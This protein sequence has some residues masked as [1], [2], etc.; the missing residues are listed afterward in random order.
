MPHEREFYDGLKKYDNIIFLCHRNADVD[1]LGSAYALSRLFGGVVGVQ[2][3]LSTMASMLAEKLGLNVVIAPRLEDYGIVLVV[4]TSTRVQTGYQELGNYGVIDHHTPG[5]LTGGSVLSLCRIASSTSELV[6]SIYRESGAPI[7]SN[8]ALSLVLAVVTDTGHFRYAKP[9][10]FGMV[11]EM[12]KDGGINYADVTD[13]LSQV[14]VDLSCRIAMLKA[15]SRLNLVRDGDY[16]LVQTRVSSFGAQAA[17]SIIGLG[18]D[19]V[20]VGSEKEG[21]KRISGRTRRGVQLDLSTIL[22]EVGRKY[23]GSGGGHAAAA[24]VVIKGDIDDALRDCIKAARDELESKPR[25][26]NAR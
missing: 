1:S 19:V 10:V 12:L 17:T 20:F 18:A 8:T 25:K 13:F 16:L 11:G 26:D 7:D 6:Y 14:P 2:D 3:S 5:D 21:E 23:N 24:G 15:S 9:D 22:Q 4:D